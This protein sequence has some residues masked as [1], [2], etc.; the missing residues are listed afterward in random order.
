MYKFLASSLEHLRSL[1]SYPLFS[2][3]SITQ[4]LAHNRILIVYMPLTGV[5][6][7]RKVASVIIIILRSIS[8]VIRTFRL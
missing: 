2:R 1:L 7:R 3:L 8:L 4:I 6:N 5:S